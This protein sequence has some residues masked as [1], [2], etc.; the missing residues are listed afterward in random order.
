MPRI[1]Q[2]DRLLE[3]IIPSGHGRTGPFRLNI[4]EELGRGYFGTVKAFA[5][6]E[7]ADIKKLLGKPAIV[8]IHDFQQKERLFH[9]LICSIITGA[10]GY[11]GGREYTFELVPW[12]DFFP[13]HRR[14][15]RLS[16]QNGLT[17]FHDPLSRKR[18]HGF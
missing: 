7:V 6:T 8:K 1:N 4:K 16:R 15:S 11:Q 12:L 17:D 2:Q 3:L 10:V 18:T 5:L 13:T 14:L 9:G